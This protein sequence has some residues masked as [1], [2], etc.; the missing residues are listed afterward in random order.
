MLTVII[1]CAVTYATPASEIHKAAESGDLARIR[2]ILKK[3]NTLVNAKN[4]D[5]CT[6]LHKV[7][8]GSGVISSLATPFRGTLQS[9]TVREDARSEIVQL[10][11]ENG[12]DVNA[13][14]KYGKTPLHWAAARGYEATVRLLLARGANVNNSD[15]EGGTALHE[16]SACGKQNVVFTLLVKGADPSARTNEGITPLHQ[17]AAANAGD[18]TKLLLVRSLKPDIVDD[19]GHTPLHWAACLGHIDIVDLLLL[20][21]AKL[22]AKD[23]EERTPLHWAAMHGHKEIV[24][25]LLANGADDKAKDNRQKTPLDVAITGKTFGYRDVTL[26]IKNSFP[27]INTFSYRTAENKQHEDTIQLLKDYSGTK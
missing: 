26:S 9:G 2:A 3:D 19:R 17:A 18:V 4:E 27:G 11:I 14:N 1:V 12:A 13:N 25:L 20:S 16:A 22:V 23:S 10:L 6:P 7:I 21:G 8:I 24:E 15:S 5:G